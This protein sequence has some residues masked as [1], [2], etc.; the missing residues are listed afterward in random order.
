MSR[1]FKDQR[2]A[3][4]QDRLETIFAER[5]TQ[6]E[7]KARI[8]NVLAFMSGN[9]GEMHAKALALAEQDALFFAQK[10]GGQ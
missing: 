3:T 1:T 8:E 2:T 10:E 9:Y 6:R 5:Y 4:R 7:R